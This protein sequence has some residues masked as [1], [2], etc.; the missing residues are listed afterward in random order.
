MEA[1]AVL[2]YT[3]SLPGRAQRSMS[4]SMLSVHVCHVA[5]RSA[6]AEPAGRGGAC[7]VLYLYTRGGSENEGT[8][9]T[10]TPA[11]TRNQIGMGKYVVRVAG[12]G[13][14]VVFAGWF[15]DWGR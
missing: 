1:G 2:F 8:A 12:R 9:A 10:A 13:W 3:C 11:Q 7:I 14:V 15:L 6:G 5:G 4:Y